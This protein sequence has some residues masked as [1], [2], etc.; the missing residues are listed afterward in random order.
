MNTFN[1][2]CL[3][4]IN[5]SSCFSSD[6]SGISPHSGSD[7]TLPSMVVSSLQAT[8]Y[9]YPT[10]HSFTSGFAFLVS[11][12]LSTTPRSSCLGVNQTIRK[13]LVHAY[14][15]PFV[16]PAQGKSSSPESTITAMMSF[17]IILST[18]PELPCP[19]ERE[20]HPV[21]SFRSNEWNAKIHEWVW[22]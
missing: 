5:Q 1:I 20:T 15:H 6:L 21:P 16:F 14:T 8:S 22:L 10:I 17:H 9:C 7:K 3:V 4:S 18:S 2:D 11:Y 12:V 19:L 13:M